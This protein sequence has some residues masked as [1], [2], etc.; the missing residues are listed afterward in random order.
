MS[1]IVDLAHLL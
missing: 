1:T